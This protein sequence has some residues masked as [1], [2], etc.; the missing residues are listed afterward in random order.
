MAA[1]RHAAL[2]AEEE[3]LADGVHGLEA[4]A[5]E[6][7]GDV[8]HRRPRVRRLDHE[9]LADEH[10]QPPRGAAE[11]IAL[12]HGLRAQHGAARTGEEAGLEGATA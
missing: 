5:V 2:E 8:L 1:Q 3:V 6:P 7:L 9:L 10:L 4:P 12:R 11:R